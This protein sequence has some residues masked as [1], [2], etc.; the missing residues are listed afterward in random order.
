[1]VVLPKYYTK[2]WLFLAFH[3]ILLLVPLSNVMHYAFV[4]LIVHLLIIIGLWHLRNAVIANF[5]LYISLFG[6]IAFAAFIFVVTI[7]SM[8]SCGH[9]WCEMHE[10]GDFYLD[11]L[12]GILYFGF[13]LTI[14]M[15]H[16]AVLFSLQ[17]YIDYING[18]ITLDEA[19]M[20]V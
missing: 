8:I 9:A 15:A 10:L 20:F 14:T 3:V 12:S 5:Y 17:I 1:M 2:L 7:N 16:A 6:E 11:L 4:V 13:A 18:D 19:T